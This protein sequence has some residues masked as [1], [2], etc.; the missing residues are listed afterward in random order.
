[1]PRPPLPLNPHRPVLLR[2]PRSPVDTWHLELGV[3]PGVAPTCKMQ[4][5][6]LCFLWSEVSGAPG[7]QRVVSV[8]ASP[9]LFPAPPRCPPLP[10]GP[11]P[12]TMFQTR[13][14]GHAHSRTMLVGLV[15]WGRPSGT[16]ST[17]AGGVGSPLSSVSRRS[18]RWGPGA[19]VSR[20]FNPIQ[21][22][23]D[24]W[25]GHESTSTMELRP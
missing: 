9:L 7:S 22:G 8:L 19:S 11:R 23:P 18:H 16:L 4:D 2:D 24:L 5:S 14:A 20:A 13:S 10:P 1:M 12:R 3:S 15:V 17:L 21:P 6:D 25:P